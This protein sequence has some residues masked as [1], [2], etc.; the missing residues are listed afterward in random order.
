MYQY[1]KTILTIQQ[2]KQAYIDSGVEISSLQ[3]VEEAMRTIGYY[4]LR[5]YSFQLYDNVSKK[6]KA[7]TKFRDILKIYYF[8]QKLSNLIFFM[9]SKIEVALRVCLVEALLEY[10]DALILQDSSIFKDKKKYWQ[11]MSI[12]SSEIAR[13]NDLFIKHNFNKYEGEV[14]VWGSGRNNFIWDIIQTN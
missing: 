8:D 7:G 11:N 4:R 3:E 5:G 14:P 2:Q 6:Y 12:V 10:G 9:I 13:S 1:P